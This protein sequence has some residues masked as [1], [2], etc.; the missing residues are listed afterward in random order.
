MGFNL[1]LIYIRQFPPPS[2]HNLLAPL[3]LGNQQNFLGTK[4]IGEGHLFTPPSIVT[5]MPA[6]S[7]FGV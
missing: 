7:I 6:A 3:Q 4:I 5:T 1:S 2:T